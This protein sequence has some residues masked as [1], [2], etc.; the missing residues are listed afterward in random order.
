MNGRSSLCGSSAKKVPAPTIA[1]PLPSKSRAPKSFEGCSGLQEGGGFAVAGVRERVQGPAG[2]DALA[3]SFEPYVR[4]HDAFLLANHG[5]TTVGPTL[6]L[7]GNVGSNKMTHQS[8]GPDYGTN[9]GLQLGVPGTNG[10]DDVA[11][12]DRSGR[13]G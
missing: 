5:A 4:T 7:D 6:L 12:K 3:D 10:P 8:A 2:T 1:T 9:Y 13:S 11:R